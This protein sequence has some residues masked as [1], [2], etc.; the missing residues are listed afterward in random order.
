[1]M[2]HPGLVIIIIMRA[3]RNGQSVILTC[4]GSERGHV[5]ELAKSGAGNGM[6]A[7]SLG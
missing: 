5:Y 6:K 4:M 1:M 3:K 7:R 2:I